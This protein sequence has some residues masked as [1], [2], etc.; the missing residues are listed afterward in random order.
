[1]AD[2]LPERPAARAASVAVAVWVKTAGRSPVKTRLAATIGRA[3]AE[4]FHARS[5]RAV[6]EVVRAAADALGGA[7]L[8]PWW[9]VA[10]AVPGGPDGVAAD[11]DVT[12]AWPGFPVVAQGTGG[13]GERQARVYDALLARHAAVCFIGADA[14]QL[15]PALLVDAVHALV[16][17]PPASRADFVLGPAEDGGYWLFGGRRPIPE[18]L[19]TAVP[20]S[21]PGTFGAL[22]PRLAALGRTTLL[23]TLFDV[24]TADEFARL[25]ATLAAARASLLPAQRTLLAWLET[26]AVAPT[27]P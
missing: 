23:P 10:E 26:P 15:S 11:D 7:T 4:A 6:A 21:D 8:A 14:P 1:M 22:R 19:W 18:G 24:D 12:R 25:A 13:L 16:H 20:Y 27:E 3:R 2:A 9:A 17:A 5:V